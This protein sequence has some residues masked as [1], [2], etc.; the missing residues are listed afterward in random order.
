MM[1][2]ITCFLM[3]CVMAGCTEYQEPKVNCFSFVSRGPTS[4]D[5]NFE[6]L[7]GPDLEVVANE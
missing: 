3:L 4:M 6:A 5:C 2:K 1:Q 7:D